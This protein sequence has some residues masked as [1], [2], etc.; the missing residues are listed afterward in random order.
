MFDILFWGLT[1]ST[2]AG[3]PLGRESLVRVRESM[4]LTLVDVHYFSDVSAVAR[5]NM[6]QYIAYARGVFTASNS[7]FRERVLK[8]LM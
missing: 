4:P 1:I 6:R 3:R 8:E 7:P 5:E 2:Q